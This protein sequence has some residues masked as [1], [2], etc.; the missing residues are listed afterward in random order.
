[1]YIL[2][3]FYFPKNG[4]K[5]KYINSIKNYFFLIYRIALYDR[6]KNFNIIY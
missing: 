4:T 6:L 2:Y 1:M 3:T 5:I